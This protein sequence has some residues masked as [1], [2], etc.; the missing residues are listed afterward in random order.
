MFDTRS[1]FADE[2]DARKPSNHATAASRPKNDGEDQEARG[3]ENEIDWDNDRATLVNSDGDLASDVDGSTYCDSDS[4]SGT[5]D[6]VDAGLD[7]TGSLLWR[8]ITFIIAA[9]RISGEPNILFA[10]VTITHT[11]G[12]DNRPRE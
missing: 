8:H 2:D 10:K 4:D 12:E 7:E 6:G 11:K 1:R 3:I 9:D 5:D